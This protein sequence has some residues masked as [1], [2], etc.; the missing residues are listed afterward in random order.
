M[1]ASMM[2]SMQIQLKAIRFLFKAKLVVV[3]FKL[4]AFKFREL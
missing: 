2:K 1:H 3:V 4:L